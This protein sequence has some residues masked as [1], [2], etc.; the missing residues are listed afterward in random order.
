MLQA[1]FE[2]TNKRIELKLVQIS[3]TAN[4]I[5]VTG[6]QNMSGYSSMICHIE[7]RTRNVE[8]WRGSRRGETRIAFSYRLSADVFSA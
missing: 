2:Q 1:L 7:K 8:A 6:T 3:K 4:M 5:Q